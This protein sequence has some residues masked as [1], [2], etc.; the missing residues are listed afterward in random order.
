[1]NFV[2]ATSEVANTSVTIYET[3]I[4]LNKAACE[5]FKNVNYVLLGFDQEKKILAIKP[6]PKEIV[7]QDIYPRSQLHRLSMGKSYGRISNK[8]FLK[9]IAEY[10]N[11]DLKDGQGT[12]YNAS[13]DVMNSLLTIQ[14]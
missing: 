6:I 8:S 9:D 2:W 11:I 10:T 14:L 12:K 1:M 3:N 7:D 4:T 13:Y 5:Y